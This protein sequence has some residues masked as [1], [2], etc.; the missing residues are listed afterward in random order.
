MW[1][2]VKDRLPQEAGRYLTL[3]P[4]LGGINRKHII[5]DRHFTPSVA[6]IDS[7]G[8]EGITHWLPLPAPPKEEGK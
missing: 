4:F 7:W 2:S 5:M 1:I 6:G 8:L 3:V